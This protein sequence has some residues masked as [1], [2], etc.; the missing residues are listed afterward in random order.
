MS[1][2]TAVII[3]STE[4]L[5]GQ[6]VVT[7]R[8][9]RGDEFVF[10]ADAACQALA[11][12]FSD[13]DNEKRHGWT[14]QGP[15]FYEAMLRLREAAVSA[16]APPSNSHAELVKALEE[17]AAIEPVEGKAAKNRGAMIHMQSIARA[18]LSTTT[19]RPERAV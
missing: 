2:H 5:R 6:M 10:N 12:L 18:A 15:W 17:I 8:S 9:S 13:Y 7:V 4:N 19:A 11:Q 3:E 1:G 14:L 16:H